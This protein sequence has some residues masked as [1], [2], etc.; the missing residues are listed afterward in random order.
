[1]NRNNEIMGAAQ[2]AVEHKGNVPTKSWKIQEG[3]LEEVTS[4]MR[5]EG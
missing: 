3:F 5:P 1:M 4:T 2:D